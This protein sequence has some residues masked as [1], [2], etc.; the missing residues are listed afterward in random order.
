MSSAAGSGCATQGLDEGVEA[1]V[2]VLSSPDRLYRD[3]Q[4]GRSAPVRGEEAA[5]RSH[6]ESL[7]L[8]DERGLPVV[9]VID[10]ASH[11]LAFVGAALGSRCVPLGVDTFGQT[12]SQP[13]VYAAY[14]ID[15]ASIAT[16][17]LVALEP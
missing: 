4:R 8:P 9:T 11:A 16:A 15:A 14:G 12:G 7:V 6:L 3:W 13:E 1:T 10:G 2:L 5:R 17:A